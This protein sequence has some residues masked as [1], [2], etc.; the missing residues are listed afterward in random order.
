MN[1]LK[2]KTKTWGCHISVYKKCDIE[3]NEN[4]V[5]I[6]STHQVFQGK[7]FIQS[8]QL[9]IQF[10]LTEI[11]IYLHFTVTRGFSNTVHKTA[12]SQDQPLHP[13]IL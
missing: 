5:L 2:K 8:Q 13:G 11:S 7:R 4:F 6:F 10:D 9:I 12:C 1:E 3:L